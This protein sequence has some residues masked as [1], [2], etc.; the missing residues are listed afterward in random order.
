MILHFPPSVSAQKKQ[1]APWAAEN[2]GLEAL[3]PH[4][5]L[6]LLFPFYSPNPARRFFTKMQYYFS[7]FSI[8]VSAKI[9]YP[10]V[11][12]CTNTCVTAPANFP[13]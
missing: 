13:F 11:E 8:I 7:E 3:L 9:P 12:S 2:S 5:D 1:D 6:H 4:S 10:L